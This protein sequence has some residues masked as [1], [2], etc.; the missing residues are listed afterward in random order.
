MSSSQSP[1]N[2]DNMDTKGGHYGYGYGGGSL[3][4]LLWFIVFVIIIWLIIFA[5]KPTWAQ[6]CDEHGHKTGEVD[7]GR[8]LLWAIVIAIIICVFIWF[9]F[10]AGRQGPNPRY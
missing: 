8:A 9:F 4:W 5:V 3:T 7:A 2:L 1:A 10:Q 6:K